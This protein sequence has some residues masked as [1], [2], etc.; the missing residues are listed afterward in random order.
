MSS[1]IYAASAGLLAR[2]QQ[3]DLAANNLA[4]VNTSGFRGERVSFQTRV[5]NASP[6][7][8]SRAVNSFGVLGMTHT[9]FS[10][11]P[12]LSTGNPLDV[13]MEGAGF[14]TVQTPNG[15]QYTRN[16]SFHL[17]S[18]GA[19]VTQEGYSV[20]GDNGAPIILPSGKV[21]ISSAGVISVDGAVASQLGLADL[22]ADVP[23]TALGNAYFSA[24][25]AAAKAATAASVRQGSLESSNVSPIAGATGLIEIQ[26]N[27]EMMQRALTVLH[28]EFNRIAA[29][30]LPKV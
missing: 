29:E 17:S 6:E 18:S 11:G 9:D 3:L 7:V 25:S 22:D 15:V 20:L 16:G 14:F 19:L 5:M 24:P 13:A 1:G 4:N 2:T 30:D 23:L 28:N 26:R 21:E 8:A 10:Q 12:L 27:A